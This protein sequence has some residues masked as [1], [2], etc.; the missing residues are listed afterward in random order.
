[1]KALII[2]RVGDFGFLIGSLLLFYFFRSL[3]FSIVFSLSP[4]FKQIT[5]SF[6]G[7]DIRCLDI[8]CFFLFL[9]SMGKSAQIGLHT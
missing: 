7:I 4:Y 6:L 1:L 9:G 3:D 8:I 5:V 2:N